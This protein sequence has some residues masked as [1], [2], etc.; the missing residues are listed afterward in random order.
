MEGLLPWWK[1][2]TVC[3]TILVSA[4]DQGSWSNNVE[5][6]DMLCK[7]QDG[8]IMHQTETRAG[9]VQ[10]SQSSVFETFALHG[11]IPSAFEG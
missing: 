1:R 8:S 6:I 4:E 5:S 9:S 10:W 11:Q 2:E 7:R 3:R